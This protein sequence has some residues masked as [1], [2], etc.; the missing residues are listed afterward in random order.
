MI[1][2]TCFGLPLGIAMCPRAIV[3]DMNLQD[4]SLK[5]GVDGFEPSADLLPSRNR[6][7]YPL[8]PM[9]RHALYRYISLVELCAPPIIVPIENG[10]ENLSISN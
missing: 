7:P 3:Y 1:V 4:A 2:E 9:C 8:R 10:F 6:E 5:V